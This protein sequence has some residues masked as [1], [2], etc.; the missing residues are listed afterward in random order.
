MGKGFTLTEL[1]IV[2][3]IVGILAGFSI[4]QGAKML[5]RYRANEAKTNLSNIWDAQRRYH[6]ENR[7]PSGNP[8]YFVCTN[9]PCDLGEIENALSII[10]Y[11]E[12]FNYSIASFDPSQGYTAIA[13]RKSGICSGETMII[14]ENGSKILSDCSLWGEWQ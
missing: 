7:D 10:V 9:N 3:I 14:N 1:I 2:I 11:R 4:P 5:E 12:Y 13:T 6:L 8:V